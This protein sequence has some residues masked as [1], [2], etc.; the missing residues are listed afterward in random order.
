[1]VLMLRTKDGTP[2]SGQLAFPGGAEDPEDEGNLRVTA[3]R[4]CWEE[5]GVKVP[6]SSVLGAL[7]PLYI[8]PSDFWVQPY[9]AWSPEPPAF[10]IQEEEVAEVLVRPLRDFPTGQTPWPTHALAVRGGSIKVPGW[11]CG[12]HVLWGATAMMMAELLAVCEDA[13]FGPSFASTSTI[14]R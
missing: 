6:D 7:S 12:D 10:R 9:V 4:E 13:G 1:V 8:P 11:L 3:Q 5:V 14:E 2:H